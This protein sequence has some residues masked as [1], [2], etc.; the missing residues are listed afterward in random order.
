MRRII[1]ILTITL[2]SGCATTQ[3]QPITGIDMTAPDGKKFNGLK[4]VVTHGILLARPDLS[5]PEAE[6]E[7]ERM[8]ERNKPAIDAAM[9]R[10]TS[11][12]YLADFVSVLFRLQGGTGGEH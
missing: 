6:A 3:Y 11:A 1:A 10:V 12:I 2:L 7:A 8:Y 4:E 5:L 9:Q